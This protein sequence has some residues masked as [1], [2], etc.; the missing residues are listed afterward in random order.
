MSVEK[1]SG[2]G[3]RVRW[4][5]NG[6]NRS[7]RFT[8]KADADAW[9]R[10][11][12]RRRQLGPLA[13]AQ[14]TTV[15][16]SLGEW[17]TDRWAPE[18]GATLSK[19]TRN[20]YASSY[21]LHIAPALEDLPLTDLTVGRLRAWQAERLAAGCSPTTI[22]KARTFLSSVLRH[23]AESEAIPGNPL[24]LVRAPR[25]EHSDE[26]V[27]LPPATIEA[28][29]A[30]LAAPM[31]CPVPQGMRSGRP[32][33]AYDMPDKRTASIRMRDA[34]LVAVLAYS[35]VRPSE[36]SAV[37]WQDVGERTLLVQRA[38]EEDGTI[39]STKGRKSRSARLL[40]AL[41]ADLR[42]W[43]MAA[44]R[45]AGKALVFPRA[46]GDPWTM[47][48]WS[49]WR[50]RTWRQA[51]EKA[52]LDPVPRPYDLR[53]SFASLLLAEGRTVHYV[54]GQLGHSP[55]LTLRT[56]GHV[57]AEFEEAPRIDVDEE[58]A[59]ARGLACTSSVP[60]LAV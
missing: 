21:E 5:E 37:R 30:I 49:N 53:H 28:V 12:K 35:G 8:L 11:V 52:A 31:P 43:R 39:K 14:L 29:R 42:E 54:A 48:D 4:R 3:Y 46:D 32:R 57:V 7:R 2:G 41:A 44:G 58:I 25:A 26:V 40:P 1:L 33:R 60:R 6:S 45:P 15:A 27:A 34:T 55:E 47:E 59:R 16:P 36:A 17:I 20:R 51:C 22:Q 18:H 24:A 10:E 56:Y 50:G 23:A 9:D 19:R 13:V 38:T